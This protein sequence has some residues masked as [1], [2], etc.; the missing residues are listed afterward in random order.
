MSKEH[1]KLI[2]E[3]Y[4]SM[5]KDI[6]ELLKTKTPVEVVRMA[7]I[8]LM[9][10]KD[11]TEELCEEAIKANPWSFVYV[12]NKTPE[13]SKLAVS[14]NGY[15]IRDVEDQT[16]ELCNLAI[17]N[18]PG[19]IQGIRD[20]TEEL[21][22][23]AVTASGRAL[24]SV[25]NPSEAVCLAAVKQHGYALQW[26]PNASKEVC[27]AAV[28]QNPDALECVNDDYYEECEHAAHLATLALS[29][30]SAK[31][32]AL[33]DTTRGTKEDLDSDL[34][35]ELSTEGYFPLTETPLAIK[36]PT[37]KTLLIELDKTV[38]PWD[39][40]NPDA[41]VNVLFDKWM[42]DLNVFVDDVTRKRELATKIME[43]YELHQEGKDNA[44]TLSLL[45]NE[46]IEL[47]MLYPSSVE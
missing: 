43:E 10:I 2:D 9:F 34:F 29:E 22:L 46:A 20:Q 6:A 26:I 35:N 28:T 31:E 17:E 24:Q 36:N 32:K 18:Q 47:G 5:E 19:A 13:L 30:E 4:A 7:P 12:K 23:K 38:D 14:L 1:K 27:L 16:E 8:N 33:E 44:E 39:V 42:K 37:I 15:T 21:C 45:I 3:W 40:V 41:G 11:Q 25:V